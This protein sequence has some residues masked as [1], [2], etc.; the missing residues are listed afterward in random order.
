MLLSDFIREKNICI[1]L[2]SKNKS[3][4]IEELVALL[5]DRI[6][7]KQKIKKALLA[8]EALGSTGIGSGIALPHCKV[9]LNLSVVIGFGYSKNG[10][11]FDS[12]DGKPVHLFFL[13]ISSPKAQSLYLKSIGTLSSLLRKKH[14]R[15][16]LKQVKTIEQ[17]TDIIK[18]YEPTS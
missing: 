9:N 13:I 18:K 4:V 6:I 7:D 10:I 12:L 3:E 16:E 2:K 1:N 15:E 8:R 5:E 14:I 17:V 11:V